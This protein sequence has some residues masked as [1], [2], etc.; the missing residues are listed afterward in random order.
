MLRWI[1]PSSVVA[2]LIALAALGILLAANTGGT[3]SL[4]AE[5]EMGQVGEQETSPQPAPDPE[6]QDLQEDPGEGSLEGE[7]SE[8][9]DPSQQ[10]DPGDQTEQNPPGEQ[11]NPVEAPEGLQMPGPQTAEVRISG[12]ASYYCT[13]GA[14]GEPETVQGRRPVSYEVSVA[15]G[16]TSLDTVMAACQKISPGS[17]SVRINYDGEVVAQDETD[18]RL[19]TVSVAWNPLE[20]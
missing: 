5:Q 4:D 3:A 2:I 16:G 19:G 10:D 17:L 6:Q 11:V 15:T 18:A 1:I 8:Q 9:Q 13:L 20:E 14:L 12:N 7:Q